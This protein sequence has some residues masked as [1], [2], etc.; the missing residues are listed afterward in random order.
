MRSNLIALAIH[1]YGGIAANVCGCGV[2]KDRHRILFLWCPQHNTQYYSL[3]NRGAYSIRNADHRFE[4]VGDT[5]FDTLTYHE[6]ADDL[7]PNHSVWVL[8]VIVFF[9]FFFFFF[10]VW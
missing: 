6:S 8:R 7:S 9:F 1:L 5:R 10:C 4:S 3:H 2:W